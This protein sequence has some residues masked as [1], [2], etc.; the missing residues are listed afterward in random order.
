MLLKDAGPT[1][2]AFHGLI[3]DQQKSAAERLHDYYLKP[4]CVRDLAY[5]VQSWEMWKSP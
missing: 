5:C 3:T 4:I 2:S 1:L